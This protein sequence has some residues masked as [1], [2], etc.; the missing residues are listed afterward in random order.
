MGHNFGKE[1]LV[2]KIVTTF[3]QLVAKFLIKW[4]WVYI[5]GVARIVQKVGLSLM[6]FL[7]FCIYLRPPHGGGRRGGN[8]VFQVSTLQEIALLKP[9]LLH[10]HGSGK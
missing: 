3:D 1:V 8:F 9:K 4:N 5:S 7:R 6:V 10:I 2:E